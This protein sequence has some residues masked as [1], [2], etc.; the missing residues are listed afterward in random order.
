MSHSDA[1]VGQLHL[2]AGS[3]QAAFDTVPMGF[4]HDLHLLPHFQRDGLERLAASY[5][6]HRADYFVAGSA[7]T[8]GMAFYAVPTV[9]TTPAAALLRLDQAPTRLLLKRPEQYD[10]RFRTLLDGLFDQVARVHGGLRRDDV[11]RLESAILVTSAASTTPFHFD[12][13]VGFFSQIEGEKTYHVYAPDCLAETEL[14][15]FYQSGKVDIG[16]VDMAA[17][18][19]AKDHV[20][21]LVPGKGLHQPQNAPHWVQTKGTRSVSYTF[22]FETREARMRSRARG[23]NHYLRRVGI[24]PRAPGQTPLRDAAKGRAMQVMAR[25]R[26]AITA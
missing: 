3:L 24:T 10:L 22:V 13:E 16:Q 12:P 18:A 4:T 26:R 21:D 5:E 8:P 7:T 19:A 11:V 1:T 9:E 20:F 17:R 15:Q 25:A 23:F 14:E 2:D 6:G